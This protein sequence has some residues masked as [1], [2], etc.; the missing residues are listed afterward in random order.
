MIKGMQWI[1][2]SFEHHRQVS[3]L[4]SSQQCRAFAENQYDF[5]PL[6]QLLEHG[7]P[8]L[9]LVEFRAPIAEVDDDLGFDIAAIEFV[10]KAVPAFRASDPLTCR[11]PSRRLH[12]PQGCFADQ[13]LHSEPF[14][15]GPTMQAP[16]WQCHHPIIRAESQR[17]YSSAVTWIVKTT[18]RCDSVEVDRN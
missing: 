16:A 14:K 5:V 6:V 12:C 2:S 3:G 7:D 15:Y 1:K 4:E 13:V 11:L 17:S 8:L 18:G 9:E 10:F